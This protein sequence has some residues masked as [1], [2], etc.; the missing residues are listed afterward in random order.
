MLSKLFFVIFKMLDSVVR[1]EQASG[2]TPNIIVTHN[3]NGTTSIVASSS[4]GSTI[5]KD[6]KAKILGQFSIPEI[7]TEGK[8]DLKVLVQDFVN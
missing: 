1:I 2:E 6:D 3:A 8:L 5:V 7:K 4:Q